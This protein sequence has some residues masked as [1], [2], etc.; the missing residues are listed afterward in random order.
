MRGS[1]G[2]TEVEMMKE[3]HQLKSFYLVFSYPRSESLSFPFR[4]KFFRGP[5]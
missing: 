1:V 2:V 4:D 5:E 3:V